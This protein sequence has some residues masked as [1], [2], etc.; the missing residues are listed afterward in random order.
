MVRKR[1]RLCSIFPHFLFKK[2]EDLGFLETMELQTDFRK[3]RTDIDR[4]QSGCQQTADRH[5]QTADK[6]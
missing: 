1:G 5:K 3:T 6:L 4:L 2:K